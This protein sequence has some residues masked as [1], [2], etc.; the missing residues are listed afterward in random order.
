M[1]LF[2]VYTTLRWFSEEI[3][4]TSFSQAIPYCAYNLYN[5]M[6]SNARNFSHIRMCNWAYC[7]YI[8]WFLKLAFA[9]CIRKSC[10]CNYIGFYRFWSEVLNKCTILKGLTIY[11]K[12]WTFV[13]NHFY[14][15]SGASLIRTEFQGKRSS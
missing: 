13:E 1:P 14:W 15:R 7:W 9:Y 10:T 2:I 11:V 8:L 6:A 5:Q 3:S 4:L 12:L